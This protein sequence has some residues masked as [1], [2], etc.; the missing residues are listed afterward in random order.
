MT[1]L[2]MAT[3]SLVPENSPGTTLELGIAAA[4]DLTPDTDGPPCEDAVEVAS[5]NGDA[6]L[7]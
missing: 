1:F 7:E 4:Q 5:R 6:D 2:G 3:P